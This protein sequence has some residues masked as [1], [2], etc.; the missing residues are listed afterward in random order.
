M[1]MPIGESGSGVKIEDLVGSN[2]FMRRGLPIESAGRAALLER[3]RACLAESPA[4]ALQELV[5]MAVDYCHA[6]SSGI[7]LEEE[8]P[9]GGLQFR[10]V[11]V[12][13][14]FSQYLNGVT[15]RFYS[16]CGTC[17]DRGLP[18]RY[19]VTLPYYNFLGV[20]AEPILDGILI[21]WRSESTRGTLWLV[22]HRS[23]NV[24][25]E[26]DYTLLQ[27]LASFA[28]T[29]VEKAPNASL[30]KPGSKKRRP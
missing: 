11:A 28:A 15:P 23:E 5:Q 10:W 6:D 30:R 1:H 9:D 16:P 19:Q 8:A 27:A 17:L 14:S 26:S 22:S 21:P 25:T 24:F 4:T 29:G 20:T 3:L 13:G 18:Q 2:A 7:S 12:A